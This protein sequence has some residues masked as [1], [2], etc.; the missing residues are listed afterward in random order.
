MARREYECSICGHYF[1]VP[2]LAANCEKSHLDEE[3]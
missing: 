3:E 2:S 1:V